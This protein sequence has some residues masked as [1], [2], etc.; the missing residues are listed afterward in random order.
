MSIPLTGLPVTLQEMNGKSKTN[1]KF[2]HDAYAR[3]R[4]ETDFWGQI[5][6][7]VNGKPVSDEQ[8]E[9]II[10]LIKL[11]LGIRESDTLLDLACG[12]GALASRIFNDC[13]AYLGVDA[14]E[15]LITVAQRHFA[16]EP[17]V[18]FVLQD[19]DSYLDQAQ[20][21]HQF[22]IALCYGSFSYFSHTTA[23]H[24]LKSLEEKFINLRSVYIG[25]IPNKKKWKQFYT[26][27]LPPIEELDDHESQIGIWWSLDEFSQLV[28][29]TEWVAEFVKLPKNLYSSHYRYD[30]VLTRE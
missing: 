26:N 9:L 12:N 1:R 24:L 21:P 3:T 7:T 28:S 18:R 25:N 27:Q 6:R 11:G 15:Y 13:K 23:E 29:S 14:S 16:S 22:T 2:D 17:R 4:S 30:V 19:I 10:H 5:R 8:I 20:D